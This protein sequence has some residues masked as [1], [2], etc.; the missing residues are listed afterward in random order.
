MLLKKDFVSRAG[1]AA[2]FFTAST[3][4]ER[5]PHSK[6]FCTSV[7]KTTDAFFFVAGLSNCLSQNRKSCH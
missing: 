2:D 6:A 5:H 4:N 3:L 7:A 1:H